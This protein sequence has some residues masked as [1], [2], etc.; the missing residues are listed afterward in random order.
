MSDVPRSGKALFGPF[1]LEF[2]SGELSRA[3]RNVRL[4][5]QA[6]EI[7]TILLD[8]PGQ[9]VPRE[10]IRRRL[11][12]NGTL[13][14]FEHSINE[15]VKKLRFALRDSAENP[16]YIETVPRRGYRLMVSVERLQSSAAVGG[17]LCPGSPIEPSRGNLTGCLIS[18]YRVLR[19]IGGGA[20]G[21]VYQ[22]EDLKLGRR[23]ALK[24]LPEELSKE[25]LAIARLRREACAASALTHPN[26]CT[27]YAIEEEPGHPF[28]AM[29][30]LEGA[31]LRDRIARQQFSIEEVFEIGIQIAGALQASHAA[32]IIHRDIKP[33]N[34]FITDRQQ[35]KILDFGVAKYSGAPEIQEA[36]A[37]GTRSMGEDGTRIDLTKT[38]VTMG[39]AAYMSPEQVAAKNW[40]V[41]R[42]CS[43][44]ASS[45]TKW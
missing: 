14:E 24:F 23:V 40:T 21:L 9:V 28:I 8:R 34:I 15:A 29:E 5:G 42:T 22:A 3:G 12:P 43:H 18:H 19:V 13:V 30:L 31:N 37:A 1:E 17:G 26:I 25:P 4:Q 11:W 33:A 45:Y 44:S 35:V 7:L 41:A 32:G 38:G 39:T 16:R 36:F 6:F 10:E 2:S 20:M 27:L